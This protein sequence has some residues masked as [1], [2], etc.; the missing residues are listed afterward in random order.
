[1]KIRSRFFQNNSL[2]IRYKSL[3]YLSIVN[4][5]FDRKLK[6]FNARIF[7]SGNIKKRLGQK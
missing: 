5:S 3:E 7:K 4:Q 1:M 6:G 2:R